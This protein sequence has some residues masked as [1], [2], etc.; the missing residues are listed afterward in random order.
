MDIIKEKIISKALDLFTQIGV[1]VVTMDMISSELGMSKKTLY[2]HFSSKEELIKITF[3]ECL[4][5]SMSD[6]ECK[7]KNYQNII[8]Q[9]L[10]ILENLSEMFLIKKDQI[11]FQL[12]K[13]YPEIF[14]E[15]LA[16]QQ[17]FIKNLL[18][19]NISLGIDEGVYRAKINKKITA[20]YIYLTIQL[21]MDKTKTDDTSSVQNQVNLNYSDLLIRSIA[22]KKGVKELE[23]LVKIN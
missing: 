10:L 21:I 18:K 16:A 1:K 19:N 13:F 5:C 4:S 15:I 23:K 11:T 8:H 12:E 6:M 9:I 22:T 20:E 3:S 2:E 7:I 14:H 17:T